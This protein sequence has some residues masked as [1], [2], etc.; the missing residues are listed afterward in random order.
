MTPEEELCTA[1][2]VWQPQR[3]W[4]YRWGC[5]LACLAGLTGIPHAELAETLQHLRWEDCESTWK[6]FS[7]A[8]F[9]M[10]KQHGWKTYARFTPE[11][12]YDLTPPPGY[13][14]AVGPSHRAYDH[15][16]IVERGILWWDPHPAQSGLQTLTCYESVERIPTD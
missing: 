8:V 2:V 13:A 1:V 7:D 10:L 15:A 14:I 16:V 3:H 11:F 12:Q 9:A 6:T 4:Q 5:W